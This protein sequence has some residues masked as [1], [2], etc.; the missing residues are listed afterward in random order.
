MWNKK[1]ANMKKVLI[2]ADSSS[3]IGHG[4]IMRCLVLAKQ[5]LNKG[6]DVSFATLNLKGNLN[7]KILKNSYDV[8]ILK[9]NDNEEIE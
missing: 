5:Y 2:R 9:S 3:T 8:H 7:E 1:R 4:H 6:Y